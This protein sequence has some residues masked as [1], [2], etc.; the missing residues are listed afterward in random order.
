MNILNKSVKEARGVSS[1]MEEA[2][3]GEAGPARNP[4]QISL[5][6]IDDLIRNDKVL[7]SVNSPQRTATCGYLQKKSG[8]KL[9]GEGKSRLRQNWRSRY[10]YLAPMDT[11]LK[12]YKDGLQGSRELGEI[13]VAGCTLFLKATSKKTGMHR[14]TIATSARELKLRTD[15]DEDYH[16]WLRALKPHAAVFRDLEEEAEADVG[17]DDDGEF[18]DDEMACVGRDRTKSTK[19]RDRGVSGHGRDRG[20]SGQGRRGSASG[21]IMS[22]NGALEGWLEKKQGGKEGKSSGL[23]G[24]DKKLGRWEKR[25]FVLGDGI[26]E[27]HYFHSPS[28]YLA[29]HAPLGSVSTSAADVFAKATPKD[30]GKGK[31]RFTVKDATRELKLRCDTIADMDQWMTALTQPGRARQ[32]ST[33]PDSIRDDDDDDDDDAMSARDGPGAVDV[34]DA[35]A[36]SAAAPVRPGFSR[37][38]TAILSGKV[39]T[40]S[41]RR[42]DEDDYGIMGED[43]A[44]DAEAPAAKPPAAQKEDAPKKPVFRKGKSALALLDAASS[45]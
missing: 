30:A 1:K 4:N 29:K 34:S 14:F 7:S 12:Y 43:A 8:G 40:S 24:L 16:S 41:N 23:F 5:S 10:F 26:D 42:T 11:V 19:G 3:A 2:L 36:S 38:A 6:A 22:D 28:E 37:A 18:S 31:F 45:K 17:G 32:A 33:A 21:V 15:R 13:D 39:E 27:L 9:D 44:D 20:V 35:G 25:Y